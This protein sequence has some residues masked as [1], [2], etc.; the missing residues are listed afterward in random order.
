[1]RR[2]SSSPGVDHPFMQPGAS[3]RSAKG[4][5]WG[6]GG[7]R[8]R[9]IRNGAQQRWSAASGCGPTSQATAADASF[10]GAYAAR[11]ERTPAQAQTA[12]NEQVVVKYLNINKLIIILNLKITFKIIIS[13]F[14][15]LV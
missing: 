13:L 6:G 8:R 11:T 5:G 7:G 3:P 4:V 9:A 2:I 10:T 1:M 15:Y 14:I 12:R